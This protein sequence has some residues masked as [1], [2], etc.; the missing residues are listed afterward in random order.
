MLYVKERCFLP[1]AIRHIPSSHTTLERRNGD[2]VQVERWFEFPELRGEGTTDHVFPFF[3]SFFFVGSCSAAAALSS[4]YQKKKRKQVTMTSVPQKISEAQN[5]LI[6]LLKGWSSHS[7]V[8]FILESS[9]SCGCWLPS[10]ISSVEY[11]LKRKSWRF[12]LRGSSRPKA[13]GSLIQR[14]GSTAPP[15]DRQ[16]KTEKS[17]H[18]NF[19]NS[20]DFPWL[21][22]NWITSQQ[23]FL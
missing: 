15:R 1:P 7:L 23:K 16:V 13:H 5:T 2:K 21:A 17:H 12:L 9:V 10:W 8:A 6:T 20:F 4:P 22:W 19:F 14:E 11:D 3:V 18:S